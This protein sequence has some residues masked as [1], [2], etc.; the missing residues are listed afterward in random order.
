[1]NEFQ[2]GDLVRY[3]DPTSTRDYSENVWMGKLA[4][5]LKIDGAFMDICV[6]NSPTQQKNYI[7]Y[8]CDIFYF[9]KVS[10]L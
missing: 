4:L 5:V 3:I 9:E 7:S 10:S 8:G 6:F 1:M 2:I